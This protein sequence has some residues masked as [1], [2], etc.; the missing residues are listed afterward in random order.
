[1]KSI[2]NRKGSKVDGED[3]L[4]D[5]SCCNAG[6]IDK[7]MKYNMLQHL[8]LSASIVSSGQVHIAVVHIDQ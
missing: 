7:E 8:H 6:I 2:I 1:M 5:M 3:Q 4:Q